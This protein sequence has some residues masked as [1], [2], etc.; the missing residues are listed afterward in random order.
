[1]TEKLSALKRAERDVN[2]KRPHDSLLKFEVSS[3]EA[4]KKALAV[5][6]LTLDDAPKHAINIIVDK[7]KKKL[8]GAG[9]G[10][11][12]VIRGNPIVTVED[13]FD[14][15]LFPY[16]NAGRAS[17]YTR[18][19]D[20]DHI[21]R[22]HTSAQVPQTFKE[23]YKEF[24]GDIPDTVFIF[25]GLVYRRDVIDPKHLDV[26]HQMDIWTLRKNGDRG[27]ATDEDLL[28]L[29]TLV[30]N[31]VLP[32]QKPIIYKAVHPY[33]HN[34]IEVYGKLGDAELEILEAG[35]AHREVLRE[36]GF[37]PEIYSGL[38]SGFGL[39]RLVMALK[40]LPDVRYLRSTEPRIAK[41]MENTDKFKEV[42]MMPPISRD[43]SYTIPG[44]FT[45]EDIN[46]E[47]KNAF[48]EKSYLVE[49]VVIQ[50]RTKYVDLPEIAREKLGAQPGQDNV[51]VRITLRHPDVTLTKKEANE[52]YD[53]AYPKL[54]KGTKGYI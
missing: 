27:P 12:R 11:I 13:N 40:S 45:E 37:D 28:R 47:I 46:E 19:V 36:A 14:K 38:A 52:L 7:V 51:L 53:Q 1:M 29:V 54:H 25:L 48:G 10:S 5:Q 30:F 9:F 44:D 24:N 42:S 8:E 16:D 34:G 33:T 18:Y 50:S 26:F 23:F 39:D 4:I 22:T 2:A 20:E 21:L 43:M 41:Q 3:P 35:L 31:A 49:N 17:T 32:D 6:D 15:L